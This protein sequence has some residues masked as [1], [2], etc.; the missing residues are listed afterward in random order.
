MSIS[1]ITISLFLHSLLFTFNFNRYY[2][3]VNIAFWGFFPYILHVVT[4]ICLYA[5][6]RTLNFT[7]K[8]TTC[9]NTS[10]I[11]IM[12]LS[13]K[14]AKNTLIFFH[15][16]FVSSNAKI[17]NSDHRLWAATEYIKAQGTQ[18]GCVFLLSFLS[19]SLLKCSLKVSFQHLYWKR[20]T[21][22]R[23]ARILHLIFSYMNKFYTNIELS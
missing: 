15:D 7:T 5:T 21:D 1:W 20:E 19:F 9:S 11:R 22:V 23:N 8:L 18:Q 13:P 3:A 2:T 4:H 17:K 16:V 14:P 10:I 6:K 12:V